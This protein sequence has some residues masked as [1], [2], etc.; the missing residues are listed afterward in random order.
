[1]NVAEFIEFLKTQDQTAIVQ[2]IVAE[3]Y[4]SAWD[5]AFD[6]IKHVEFEDWTTNASV[7][8]EMPFYQKKYLTLGLIK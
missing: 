2:V 5:E 6:P 7:K 4:D 3:P 1:M 8:P